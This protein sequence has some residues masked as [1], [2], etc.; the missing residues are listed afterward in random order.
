MNYILILYE[1]IFKLTSSTKHRQLEITYREVV[2]NF[3]LIKQK[4]SEINFLFFFKC[5][6]MCFSFKLV[7]KQKQH[8]ITFLF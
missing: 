1:L 6:L 5:L 7:R 8:I 4:I 2:R 3:K